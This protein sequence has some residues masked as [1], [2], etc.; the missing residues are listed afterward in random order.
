VNALDQKVLIVTGAAAGIGYGSARVLAE[1]GAKVVLADVNVA[2]VDKAA[3]QLRSDG[4]EVAS[5]AVD[6]S[7]ESSVAQLVR[8]A[9]TTYGRLDGAFNNAAI[10]GPEAMTHN[11]ELADWERTLSVNLTGTMLCMKYEIRA[12]LET[13]GGAIVNASSGAGIVGLENSAPYVASKHA[14]I[15]ISRTAALEYARSNVRVNAICPAVIQTPMVDAAIAGDPGSQAT[16][17]A[18][19]PIGRM[20]QPSEIGTAVAFLLSDAASLVT[21]TAMAVDGGLF[22]QAYGAHR[23]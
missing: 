23:S 21:G 8:F 10:R 5:C 15:G 12:M 17:D 4:L 13:G 7:D 2:G 14:V 20:G 16:W 11:I 3:A 19:Q 6:V 22:A 18:M 9:T 1:Q